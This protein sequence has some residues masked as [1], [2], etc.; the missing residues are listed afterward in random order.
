VL[1]GLLLFALFALAF[2]FK[3]ETVRASPKDIWV[4]YDYPTIQAAINAA[5]PG[6]VIH[7]ASGTYAPAVV[8]KS[9]TLIAEGE[10]IIDG[11]GANNVIGFDVQA[12]SVNIYN[13]KIQNGSRGSYGIYLDGGWSPIASCIVENN[14]IRNFEYGIFL[15]NVFNSRV[16]NNT[17][18]NCDFGIYFSGSSNNYIV[19]N[20]IYNSTGCGI[21]LQFNPTFNVISDN[22]ITMIY[23]TAD[24]I[25]L[26][27][28]SNNTIYN[29]WINCSGFSIT[30]D[31][32]ASNNLIYHN[33]FIGNNN[34]VK[35]YPPTANNEWFLEWPVGGNFWSNHFSPDVRSGQYQN[36]PGSDGICDDYYT[37]AE[38]VIDAYPLMGPCNRFEV[39]FGPIPSEQEISVISN[40]SISAFQMRTTQ[41]IISFN[42]SG[43]SGIGFCRVDIPNVIV[44]GLW[45]D[46]YRVLVND[47]EPLYMRNWTSDA[48]TYIY[49]QYPTLNQR[50]SNSPR[51]PISP[52]PNITYALDNHHLHKEAIPQK[53]NQ[54][55]LFFPFTFPINIKVHVRS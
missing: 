21:S 20:T 52:N 38:G 27:I 1:I 8:N 32:Q 54:P 7:V 50:S 49:F 31:Y 11:Q 36:Q 42:V 41:R 25:R 37:I 46:N 51:I 13:F 35:F 12:S 55:P 4:P 17:V 9:L 33:N 14:H 23:A 5:D 40:S 53:N 15:W 43:E 39:Q 26:G 45:Q 6:D 24:G 2:T 22:N 48:T 47:Q 29:N 34:Q 10:A 3:A 19:A 18:T 28:C 16:F 44:S 30:V